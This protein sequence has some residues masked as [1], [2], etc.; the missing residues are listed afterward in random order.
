MEK[1]TGPGIFDAFLQA[2]NLTPDGELIVTHGSRLL[3]VRQGEMPA[4]LKM[5]VKEDER[6]GA[7]MMQYWDGEDAA[8]VFAREDNVILMERAMGERSLVN[9]VQSGRDEEATRIICG[10]TGRLHQPRSKPLPELIP[11]EQW[12]RELFRHADK[13]GGIF[14]ECA[15]TARRLIDSQR[16]IVPLHGDIH[17]ENILDFGERGWL[18]I[19]PM[20]IT[21]ERAFDYVNIFSN[22]LDLDLVTTPGRFQQRLAVVTQTSGLERGRLL[23]WIYAWSGLSATWILE[24]GDD[25]SID[26]AVAGMAAAAMDQ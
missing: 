25:A 19:D 7:L 8:K 23:Q 21:G 12:F 11:L 10:V 4:M 1:T 18:V 17:H 22:P 20:R 15:A 24:D 9:M 2:W 16:E 6:F 5:G 26:L 3:P 14:P 13:Y